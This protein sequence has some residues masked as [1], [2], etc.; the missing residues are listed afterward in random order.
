[1]NNLEMWKQ[2]EDKYPSFSKPENNVTLKARGLKAL[3]D[4]AYEEGRSSG[5]RDEQ[6]NQRVKDSGVEGFDAMSMFG[7]IFKNN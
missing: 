4:Q 6:A 1:M 7:N 2:L 5:K 3:I